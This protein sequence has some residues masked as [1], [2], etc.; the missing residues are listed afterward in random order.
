MS[1]ELVTELVVVRHGETLWNAQ[2]RLQGHI[3]GKLSPLGHRQA[4]A[5]AERLGREAFHALYSSDLG[6]AV[7]TA[8][9]IAS[10]L[11]LPLNTDQRLRERCLGIFQSLTWAQV[12]QRYPVEYARFV[13]GRPDYEIPDGESSRQVHDRVVAAMKDIITR[14]AGQRVAIVTHGGVLHRLLRLAVGLPLEAPRRWT[15]YNGSINRFAVH[16]G[17]WTLQTWGEIEHLRQIG[18]SDDL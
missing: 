6:R 3:D 8:T 4:Q 2:G 15:I 17:R 10:R 12:Q 14:H 18:T 16:D 11:G 13:A 9:C 1:E 7:Q 5:I